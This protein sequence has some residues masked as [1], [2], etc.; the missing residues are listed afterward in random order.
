MLV[1]EAAVVLETVALV[2]LA[3]EVPVLLADFAVLLSPVEVELESAAP[4]IL[5][6]SGNFPPADVNKVFRRAFAGLSALVHE[7]LD[8]L[9]V[10]LAE[11]LD[12][13]ESTVD[14]V[15]PVAA[16]LSTPERLFVL[17]FGSGRSA[18]TGNV[19]YL[20]ALFGSQ[21]V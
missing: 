3:E 13:V 12:L 17:V 14:S 7:S 10:V 2:L 21:S 6:V 18:T 5:E 4:V 9:D 1:L 19:G 11:T 20:A 16:L 8:A 15:V